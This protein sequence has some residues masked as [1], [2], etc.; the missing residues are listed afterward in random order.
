MNMKAKV[1]ILG[2]GNSTG[3]PAIGNY[4]GECDPDEPK[5]CRFRSSILL[6]TEKTKIVVD[7][8]PDFRQQLT[9]E[10]IHT[11]DAALITHAHGDHI[12]GMDELRIITYRNKNLTPLYADAVT[13]KNL[14]LRFPYLFE[15]GNHALY[16]KVIDSQLVV[17]GEPFKV[18]EIPV[19]P[20]EQDHGSCLSTGYRFGD[21]GY[22]VDMVQLD[23]AAVE[24]LKG[25]KIWVV[26]CAAYNHIDNVVHANLE[27]VYALNEKIGAEQV[28]LS[29]LTL[30]MDYQ[31]LIKELK[32]GYAPA[33][34]GLSFSIT[35]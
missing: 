34:D 29:S 3:V 13:L 19:L 1:T 25:V 35:L 6:E 18:N 7:T 21:F 20:F 26:D 15:G 24:A 23:D 31:T 32:P 10:N 17:S 8:G 30:G 9:R 11:I 22:S 16:P 5:N 28:Y 4:W 27:T 33:Y 14:K 2:C 12:N